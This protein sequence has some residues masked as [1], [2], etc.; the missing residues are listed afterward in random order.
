MT[1]TRAV[2]RLFRSNGM[3]LVRCDF[4]VCT[5]VL[6]SI[7]RHCQRQMDGWCICLQQAQSYGH[8]LRHYDTHKDKV[9]Y[10]LWFEQI[11]LGI[12]V[13]AINARHGV[14]GGS[15]KNASTKNASHR[16]H[17]HHQLLGGCLPTTTRRLVGK[18][19]LLRFS[20]LMTVRVGRWQLTNFEMRKS[21]SRHVGD[22]ENHHRHAGA[23]TSEGANDSCRTH[24]LACSSLSTCSRRPVGIDAP[25]KPHCCRT[26]L[27]MGDQHG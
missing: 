12:V 22:G 5:V 21:W 25:A 11:C 17:H 4:F 10:S 15:T 20:N 6:V 13:C 24:H 7:G 1:W 14:E 9:S 27:R 8:L 18:G 23:R 26:L 16:T 19:I 3:S 2:E